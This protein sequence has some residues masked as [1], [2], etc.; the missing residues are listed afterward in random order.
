V[1][2]R[3][4]ALMAIAAALAGCSD[5]RDV[6]NA[7]WRTE[8]DSTGDTIR[9]K[10]TGPMPA[11][12]IHELEPELRVGAE[13]GTEEETFG[14]IT[15][16]VGTADGGLLVWDTQ[17]K[18]L[19]RFGADGKFVSRLGTRGSGPGEHGHVNGIARLPNGGWAIWDADGSRINR[20]REDGTFIDLVRSPLTGWYLTDGLRADREGRIYLWSPLTRDSLTNNVTTAGYLGLDNAGTIVDT[21]PIPMWGPEPSA[22]STQSPDGGSMINWAR[23]WAPGNEGTLSPDGGMVGGLGT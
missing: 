12:S 17:A 15:D 22:L 4:V 1:N 14:S 5:G 18:A 23:P 3:R 6:A 7:A 8:A 2:R 13:S 19:R 10:I 21:V 9:V 20:Y 16:V 11:S